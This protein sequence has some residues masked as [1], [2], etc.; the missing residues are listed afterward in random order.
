MLMVMW[1]ETVPD[2]WAAIVVALIAGSTAAVFRSCSSRERRAWE[3]A[4][5]LYI[6][7]GSVST[8]SEEVRRDGPG[9]HGDLR[10][11]DVHSDYARPPG[12]LAKYNKE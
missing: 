4:I 12:Q 11:E 8:Q 10:H 3:E 5:T 9:S 1:V 6:H 2:A 7:K